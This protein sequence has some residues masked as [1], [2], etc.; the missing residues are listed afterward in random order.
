MFKIEA[1]FKDKVILKKGT[2]GSD[3]NNISI[4]DCIGEKTKVHGKQK[5]LNNTFLIKLCAITCNKAPV[6][7]IGFKQAKPNKI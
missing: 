2:R 7:E 4:K 5:K 3:L 1:I 6:K